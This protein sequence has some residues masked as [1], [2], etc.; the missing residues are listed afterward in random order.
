MSVLVCGPYPKPG[1]AVASSHVT[2]LELDPVDVQTDKVSRGG[3]SG[4]TQEVG[5]E[6][7][8]NGRV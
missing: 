8:G 6:I 1:A 4:G 7:G 2:Y 5:V 3:D